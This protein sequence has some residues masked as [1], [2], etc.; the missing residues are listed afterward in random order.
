MHH[1]NVRDLLRVHT[2]TPDVPKQILAFITHHILHPFLTVPAGAQQIISA[3]KI[4]KSDPPPQRPKLTYVHQSTGCSISRKFHTMFL[5][6]LF[7]VCFFFRP[8]AW[9]LS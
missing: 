5:S 4:R 8:F 2:T 7:Q 9:R 3:R 1:Y 6:I